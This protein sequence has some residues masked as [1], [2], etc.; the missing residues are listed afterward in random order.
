MNLGKDEYRAN[1]RKVKYQFNLKIITYSEDRDI[2]CQAL[3]ER[4]DDVKHCMDTF[5]FLLH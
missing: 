2:L 1:D 3:Q 5:L 4:G